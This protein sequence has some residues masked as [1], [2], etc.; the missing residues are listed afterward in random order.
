M[1]VHQ[2]VFKI[3]ARK[4]RKNRIL[5]VFMKFCRNFLLNSFSF[6]AVLVV[7]EEDIA[8]F[9]DDFKEYVLTISTGD[10]YIPL[11]PTE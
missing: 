1:I 2:I 6:F 4:M 9:R 8:T 3:L 11:Y 10:L 5:V 7:P